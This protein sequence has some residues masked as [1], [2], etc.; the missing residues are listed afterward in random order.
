MPFEL[1]DDSL[2]EQYARRVIHVDMDAF[3]AS[4]E[5]RDEPEL[6]GKPLVVGGMPDSRGVVAACSYE[7]RQYGIRSAMSCS[8]AAR[9][10]PHAVFLRPNMQKYRDVSSEIHN[11]FRRH[12]DQIEP[13]ALDEAYLD[14]T[15][16]ELPATEIAKAIKSEI[17]NE[18]SLIASAGVSYNKF[19]AKIASEMDKPNGFFVIRPEQAQQLIANLEVRK[20]HGI[21]PVTAKKMADLGIES[22][23]QLREFSILKLQKYFGSAAEYYYQISR[24]I[25]TR[26]VKANRKRLSIGSETTFAENIQ[27]REIILENLCLLSKKVAEILNDRGKDAQSLTIKV[28]FSDFKQLTRTRSVSDVFDFSEEQKVRDVLDGL[29]S[30]VELRLPVRLLGVSVSKLQDKNDLVFPAQLS[31]LKD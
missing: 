4:V 25:D 23:A 26:L 14:V 11:I 2:A 24:G 9:L 1:S 6:A 7:A 30:K 29:L 17:K 8:H 3:Y 16:D 5:Q 15:N 12:S 19:L 22:G 20:F 10:C 13:L 28:K 21:G 27:D 18:L 31:L